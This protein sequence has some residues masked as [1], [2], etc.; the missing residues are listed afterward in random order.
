M[1][2]LYKHAKA[3]ITYFSDLFTKSAKISNDLEEQNSPHP[4]AGFSGIWLLHC[5]WVAGLE[6]CK[7]TQQPL[8]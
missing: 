4:I 3:D 7:G 1:F 6:S 8:L 5:P 2:V